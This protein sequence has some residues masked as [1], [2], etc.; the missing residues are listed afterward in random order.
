M[1]KIMMMMMM[2]MTIVMMTIS[3][4]INPKLR[5]RA[6]KVMTIRSGQ[7]TALQKVSKVGGLTS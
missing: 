4:W 6:T 7:G 5:S 1:S 3:R 2:M